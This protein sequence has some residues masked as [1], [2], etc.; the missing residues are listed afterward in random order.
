MRTGSQGKGGGQKR[1]KAG[2]SGK[3]AEKSINQHK[4]AKWPE[5][6]W[7]LA[8]RACSGPFTGLEAGKR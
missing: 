4:R 8:P 2:K 7:P 3:R 1:A 5:L 6:A